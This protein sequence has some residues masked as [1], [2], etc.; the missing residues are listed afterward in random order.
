MRTRGRTAGLAGIMLLM[1]S[2]GGEQSAQ[3]ALNADQAVDSTSAA[4]LQ[5]TKAIFH[6]IPSPMETAALLRKAG[7]QY[8]RS[9][10][11]DPE[12]NSS[13]TAAS[14]QALNLGIYGA[15]LSYASVN[16]NTHE[17]ML[18]TAAAQNL[19]KRLN[20][21]SV[22]DQ[23]TVDRMEANRNDRDSLLN[24]ISETYWN[25][26]AYLKENRRENISA[27]MIVGGWVEGLYI[28]TQVCRTNDTPE[29]RQRIAEQK[30]PLG[31]LIALVDTYSATDTTVSS[32]LADIRQL[33]T[34]F[35]G[36]NVGGG[37]T[38]VSNEGGVAVIGGGAP[39]ATLTDDQLKAITE[40]A[41]TLRNTYIN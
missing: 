33:E 11:N 7:A 37:P 4:R 17:S 12:R 15:D 24:I 8:D 3:D 32:V 1:A 13:Y 35:A 10:L 38:T 31:D 22:F 16:N 5:R 41:A 21:S 27:L 30:L 26:D 39:A 2:C 36:V 18:Y 40:R 19:A 25:V 9:I 14:K 23:A 28:A 20:V 6:N 29:L 34:V